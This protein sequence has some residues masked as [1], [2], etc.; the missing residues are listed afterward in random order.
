MILPFRRETRNGCPTGMG[1]ESDQSLVY[2]RVRQHRLCCAFILF[3]RGD[4]LEEKP[5]VTEK[6]IGNTTYIVS[7][8]G[9]EIPKAV[10]KNKL[11][12]IIK[13]SAAFQNSNVQKHG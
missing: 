8:Y 1:R 9:S 7:S 2:E 11:I 13:E 12:K 10:I 6:K 5:K 4:F 3:F